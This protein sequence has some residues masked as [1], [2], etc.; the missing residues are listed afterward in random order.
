MSKILI[1]SGDFHIGNKGS[2]TLPEVIL[3][4]DIPSKKEVISANETQKNIIK[5]WEGL[6]D[7][8][9]KP[10]LLILNGDIV[11]GRNYHESGLGLW[12]TDVN[13]QA[14][15][16]AE[17]ISWLKPRKIIGTSGSPYHSERN[18][19][20]DAIAI[21]RCRT[22]GGKKAIF[23]QGYVSANINGC[24]VH[25]MHKTTIS[26]STWQ[27][28]ATPI[29]RSLVLAELAKDTYGH[30]NVILKSHVHWFAYVGFSS[31]LGMVLPCWKAYDPFGD[32]NIEFNDPAVGYVVFE[33]ED[34]GKF[35]FDFDI[36]HF[37]QSDM[38]PD[39]VI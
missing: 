30:Y 20:M 21:R 6:C 33:I 1:P 17:L 4:A 29:A 11:D 36:T 28:R 32:T 25:A 14:E 37:K 26:K 5:I 22:A 12:T 19:C 31:Y 2:L 16:F 8:Y 35:T 10:D 39:V 13:Q 38:N 27:Y 34:D 24:R 15:T 23:R 7:R 3:N 18:P 9:H